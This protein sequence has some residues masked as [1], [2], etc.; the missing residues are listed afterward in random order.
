[1]DYQTILAA[2]GSWPED[3]RIRLVHEVWDQI[4]TNG[5]APRITSEMKAELDRR[6]EEL[7][8]NPGIAIPWEDSKK[9]IL[10]RLRP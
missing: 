8:Q 2:L 7:D 6:I 1:M 3:D 9:R 5:E 4:A 10:D